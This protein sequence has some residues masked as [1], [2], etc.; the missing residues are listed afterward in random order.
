MAATV[1][2][3]AVVAKNA[4]L[5]IVTSLEV[6]RNLVNSIMTPNSPRLRNSGTVVRMFGTEAQTELDNLKVVA[7]KSGGRMKYID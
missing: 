1:A 5:F 4:R 7:T 3:A 2:V 6:L